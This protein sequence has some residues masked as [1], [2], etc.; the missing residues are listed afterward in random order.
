MTFGSPVFPKDVSGACAPGDGLRPSKLLRTG[1]SARTVYRSE[2]TVTKVKGPCATDIKCRVELEATD[3][4]ALR[5]V[6]L[7][8]LKG[9]AAES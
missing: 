8:D 6:T 5:K 3:E 7:E 9:F 4:K 2:Y 1:R